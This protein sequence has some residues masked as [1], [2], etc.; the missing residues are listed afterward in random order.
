MLI[1]VQQTGSRFDGDLQLG[2]CPDSSNQDWVALVEIARFRRQV[3][4][5][6]VLYGR[7]PIPPNQ[8]D[9]TQHAPSALIFLLAW[10]DRKEEP[11]NQIREIDY[12]V[13]VFMRLRARKRG[14]FEWDSRSV[15]VL[16]QR[17][18]QDLASLSFWALCLTRCPAKIGDTTKCIQYAGAARMKFQALLSTG[19]SAVSN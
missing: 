17:G 2:R 5:F 9:C 11:P 4:R 15:E 1:C 6:P 12:N 18:Q 8:K 7:V 14:K 13:D 10:Q 16:E 19:S 3:Y